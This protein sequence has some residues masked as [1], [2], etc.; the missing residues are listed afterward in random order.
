MSFFV[1]GGVYRHNNCLDIDIEIEAIYH[2]P[3][4]TYSYSIA[5]LNRNWQD[6][7]YLIGKQHDVTFKKL[8]ESQWTRL[9]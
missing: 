4:N 7:K 2:K 5:Y 3:D 1:K 8:E 6:G 9:R